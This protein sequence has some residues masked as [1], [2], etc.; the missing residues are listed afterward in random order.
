MI[1]LNVG[2][3]FIVKKEGETIYNQCRKCH[4]VMF[5]ENDGYFNMICSEAIIDRETLRKRLEEKGK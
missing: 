5:F 3:D 4:K 2:H 1:M